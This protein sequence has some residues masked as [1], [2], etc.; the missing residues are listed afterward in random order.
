[1]GI[2]QRGVKPVEEME[3]NS[4]QLILAYAEG[5]VSSG[6]N[7]DTDLDQDRNLYLLL[8]LVKRRKMYDLVY[9]W[10]RLAYTVGE[11]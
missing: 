3:A 4:Q 5:L 8:P 7:R 2:V 9:R 11:D 6:S 10:Y 1:M